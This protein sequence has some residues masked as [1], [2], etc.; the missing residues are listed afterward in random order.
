M[1]AVALTLSEAARIIE[2]AI[3]D[4]SYQRESR[5]GSAVAKYLAW[6]KHRASARTLVIYE[7]YLAELCIFLLAHGDPDVD[8]DTLPMAELLLLAIDR[9]ERGSYNLARTAYS[10]FFKWAGNWGHREQRNPVDLLPRAQQPPMRVYDIFTAAEQAKLVKATEMLPLPWVQRLRVLCLVDLGIRKEE[11]RLLQP[12]NFD[13]VAKIA[14]VTGKG[15]KERA[16]PFSDDT[17]RAL[18]QFRNRPLPKVRMRDERGPYREDRK[19][20]DDDYVFF[21]YGVTKTGAVTWTD[22]SKPLAQRSLHTWWE[23]HLAGAGVRYRSLHMN[24]HTLGTDLSSAGEDLATVQDWLGHASPDTTKVY[25][26]NSRT[27]LQRGRGRLDE[28]RRQG[29]GGS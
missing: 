3:R 14:V 1:S 8:E 23:R 10:D 19:P 4:R 25:V 13:P 7:G 9:Y 11:A 2:A 27:R 22:P 26:H 18:I 20:F 24:R 28:Y 16:V 17:W 21:P 15:G 5:L 12:V 29:Q 6:K